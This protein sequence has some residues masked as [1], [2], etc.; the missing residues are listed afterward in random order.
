M[1]QPRSIFEDVSVQAPKNAPIIKRDDNPKSVRIWLWVLFALVVAMILLGGLTRLTDSGLS[2]TDWD[3]VMGAMPPMN[4]A[5]WAENFQ[6]YQSTKEFQLQNASMTLAQYK[7]IF[8]WEW[9][10]RFLGRIIGLVWILGFAIFVLRKHIRRDRLRSIFGL[11]ILIGLQGVIGILMVKSGYLGDRVD[12]VSYALATHL[13]MAFVIIGMIYWNIKHLSIS[14]EKM[15]EARR[16]GDEGRTRLARVLAGFVFLQIILGALVAGID[17]GMSYNDWPMMGGEFFSSDA[18]LMQPWWRNFFENPAL[19]QFLHRINGYLIAGL[20]LYM[21]IKN[22]RAP[23]RQWKFVGWHMMAGIFVQICVGITTLILL[24]P[25]WMALL[26]QG[27]AIA[28][29]VMALSAVFAFCYPRAQS[30][31]D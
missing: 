2:I 4:D 16:R 26:H 3:L 7:G 29:W 21:M 30:V 22:W 10:H 31:R 19:V 11:G 1:S 8:W 9:G 6:K 25:L 5:A 15:V 20:A 18:F 27:L 23:Y 17:G 12:V 24:V 28:M 13:G 14:A